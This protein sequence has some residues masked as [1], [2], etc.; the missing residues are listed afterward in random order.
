LSTIQGFLEEYLIIEDDSGQLRRA[1]FG[2]REPDLQILDNWLEDST[3]A[4][5]FVVTAP[6]GR[7]KSALIVHWL[8]RLK[9]QHRVGDGCRWSLVFVPISLRHS[10][11]R[12]EVF[13]ESIAARLA[14]CLHQ[15]LS[16]PHTDPIAY[17]KDRCRQF[18]LEAMKAALHILLVIDGADEA[19]GEA[20]TGTWFPRTST[21][22]VRIVV[23]ARTQ[24]G[25]HGPQNWINRLGWS[26]DVRVQSHSVSLISPDG[27]EELLRNMGAPIDH[28]SYRAE[29]VARLSELSQGEPLLLRLYANDLWLNRDNAN[30]LTVRDLDKMEVGFAGYFTEWLGRQKDVWHGE[31]MR[32]A[33]IDESSMYGLLGILACAYGPLTAE[34][35]GQVARSYGLQT[36]A[37]PIRDL[38][39]PLRRFV[40]GTGQ[41]S[42]LGDSG[43]VLAHPKL[44]YFLRDYLN[45]RIGAIREAFSEWG[46]TVLD[47]LEIGARRPEDVPPYLIMHLRQHFSETTAPV[48]DLLRLAER[49]WYLTW[50]A[51]EGGYR[52]FSQD[53]QDVSRL[54]WAKRS[55]ET[56][57]LVAQFRCQLILSSIRSM[58]ANIPAALLVAGYSKGLLALRQL[59]HFA[60]FKPFHE[61]TSLLLAAIPYVPAAELGDILSG[62]RL[63]REPAARAEL[64]ARL[65]PR[66]PRTLVHSAVAF[67]QSIRQLQSRTDALLPYLPRLPE[68]QRAIMVR[69]L[70][71]RSLM[72]GSEE[73]RSD[74]I[75][76]LAPH[77]PATA[78]TLSLA[79]AESIDNDHLRANALLDLIPYTVEGF[80]IDLLGIA[81]S[82]ETRRERV[83][84]AFALAPYMP[85]SVLAEIANPSG[86]DQTAVGTAAYWLSALAEQLICS[87]I[88]VPEGG[89][90]AD[91]GIAISTILSL[92]TE[93][94]LKLVRSFFYQIVQFSRFHQGGREF[95]SALA[96]TLVEVCWH[97]PSWLFANITAEAQTCPDPEVAT[98]ALGALSCVPGAL[99]HPTLTFDFVSSL[100]AIDDDNVRSG[101]LSALLPL[102]SSDLKILLEPFVESLAVSDDGSPHA[103][104]AILLA[105]SSARSSL[106]TDNLLKFRNVTCDTPNVSML[107]CAERV[108]IGNV[109]DRSMTIDSDVEFAEIVIELIPISDS[110]LSDLLFSEAQIAVNNIGDL[111]KRCR[112]LTNLAKIVDNEARDSIVTQILDYIPSAGDHSQRADA[113]EAVTPMISVPF[114]ARALSLSEDIDVDYLP[115]TSLIALINL[116]PND[117]R[118]RRF[119]ALLKR[120]KAI[121]VE[122]NRK[123]A[124]SLVESARASSGAAWRSTGR[125]NFLQE[126]QAR[127]G[128]TRLFALAQRDPTFLF[129]AGFSNLL[130]YRVSSG[131]FELL[132]PAS[133]LGYE[134]ATDD[135]TSGQPDQLLKALEAGG[136][137]VGGLVPAETP[138][139][140]WSFEKQ[141]DWLESWLN[142]VGIVERPRLLISIRPFIPA[143][144]KVEGAP[145]VRQLLRALTDVRS[146]FP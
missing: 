67:A 44:G 33:A 47:Q 129:T 134:V 87:S 40:I 131:Q 41:R 21:S 23:S 109:I 84:V 95:E 126:M 54:I 16:P 25:D 110:S 35:L 116:L 50:K 75:S 28:L 144:A 92:T 113:L 49:H 61:R 123:H 91:L 5:R 2:G 37:L 86:V 122:D 112:P 139:N 119:S 88:R 4:P 83:R 78:I 93:V 66:L 90:S 19:L 32:G 99:D 69:E 125:K 17:Y 65:A 76:A 26:T 64:L 13:Y 8:E 82:L 118:E 133:V 53:L 42:S 30:G 48:S 11:N 45:D 120:A 20:F 27:I 85:V 62:V 57:L 34:E 101:I 51:F 56:P 71:V 22:T 24:A 80:A 140:A 60:E 127:R 18:V 136:F 36:G 59:L 111:S 114:A 146:W 137:I 103:R 46:R 102:I 3:A 14:E 96:Q 121:L 142:I 29:V 132:S 52:G 98:L 107:G 143:I 115:M 94:R 104:P 128:R 12:P 138:V 124:V 31:R 43:Y 145:G 63:L 72:D 89:S 73:E 1:P 117:E 58:G 7:G 77:L 55:T 10:T 100:K 9:A 39:Y 81:R 74:T 79:L 106:T 70:L 135:V 130:G 6:A 141:R 108:A 68:K 15:E 38:L 97:I 105:S